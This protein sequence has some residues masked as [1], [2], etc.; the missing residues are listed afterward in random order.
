MRTGYSRSRTRPR[1]LRRR[2]PT[3]TSSCRSRAP[4][5]PRPTPSS[6]ATAS[7]ASRR[8]SSAWRGMSCCSCARSSR[9][10]SGSS[11]R[12][13]RSRTSRPTS[14]WT[15]SRTSG[16]ASSPCS[17][18]T[19][20]ECASQQY[21][22]IFDFFS[23]K[24]TK[25]PIYQDHA[26][27]TT[28]TATTTSLSLFTSSRRGRHALYLPSQQ[29]ARDS[30]GKGSDDVAYQSGHRHQREGRDVGVRPGVPEHGSHQK[31]A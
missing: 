16:R 29:V 23:Y 5:R 2:T 28:A 18:L 27:H 13:G 7:R 15:S 1:P 6:S 11:R 8:R 30:N 9:W 20:S 4:R 21:N 26:V 19:R 22:N 24:S 25:E 10:G 31:L 14:M 17:P 3:T 12:A